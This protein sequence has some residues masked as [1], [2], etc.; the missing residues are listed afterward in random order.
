VKAQEQGS[1]IG[2]NKDNNKMNTT[3]KRTKYKARTKN[4]AITTGKYN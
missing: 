4:N 3:I 2:N 1:R